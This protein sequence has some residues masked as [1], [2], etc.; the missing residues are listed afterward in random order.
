MLGPVRETATH[1][2]APTLGWE[3]FARLAHGAPI[4]VY[5]IGGLALSDL[6]AARS[7]G[8][9]GLAMIRGSWS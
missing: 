6:D 1:P 7:H 4:P 5:A 8:A 2:G 9:H 3:E